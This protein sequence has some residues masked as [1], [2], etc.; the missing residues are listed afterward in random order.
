MYRRSA[1]TL[2]TPMDSPSSPGGGGAVSNSLN[3]RPA[4]GKSSA[5]S[6][7]GGGKNKSPNVPTP[8]SI[9][10]NLHRAPAAHHS[11][12]ESSSTPTPP[13][14]ES[15][16]IRRRPTSG[17]IYGFNW[18]TY[19]NNPQ[20][21]A[22]PTDEEKR[23]RR[24]STFSGYSWS[25]ASRDLHKEILDPGPFLMAG[26][27]DEITSWRSSLPL[28]FAILPATVGLVFKNGSSFVTDVI[29]L[30]LTAVFLHWSVTAPW[31][32]YYSAQHVREEE[33]SVMESAFEED[34]EHDRDNDDGESRNSSDIDRSS[35]ITPTAPTTPNGKHKESSDEATKLDRA[36]VARTALKKLRIHE[37]LAL[38]SCFVCPALAT[39]M[40]HFIRDSLL[41]R[42]S[43]GL[44]S[45]FNLTIFFLAAEISPLSHSIKLIQ[46]KTLHLQ[47]IVHGNHAYRKEKGATMNQFRELLARLDELETCF[48]Q[49]QQQQSASAILSPTTEPVKN[50][51]TIDPQ[52]AKAQNATLVRDVRNAVQ[53]EI[54]ALNR[55]VRRY[56]KKAR[57]LA[58]QTESRLRDLGTR[59]DDAISLSAVV[60]ARKN[61]GLFLHRGHHGEEWSLL[62]WVVDAVVWVLML[63]VR[64]L[65][66]LVVKGLGGI[67]WV[68]G[69]EGGNEDGKEESDERRRRR[70]SKSRGNGSGSGG[71][72]S[73]KK[74][75][76]VNGKAVAVAGYGGG[77]GNGRLRR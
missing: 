5:I 13:P 66:R 63:P 41:S 36:E 6:I 25:E 32:W 48:S 43:E 12:D 61:R 2:I 26:K 34:E 71:N 31:K 23:L 56:E 51:H 7:D 8:T 65:I 64:G 77:S 59:V 10:T 68:L 14:P 11:Q 22:T 54:D 18:D 44:V 62:G 9:D 35:E 4:V 16:G 49:Q 67:T 53:P 57:V 60:A 20:S 75:A 39:W 15:S 52:Q 45:N 55:A 47:R 24:S 30:G 76:A 27:H 29:L 28:M 72:S 70:R 40:L 17:G 33:E 19:H 74:W 69:R 21:A 37:G 50:G 38:I 42:P 1:T 3:G 73:E 46:S 58:M